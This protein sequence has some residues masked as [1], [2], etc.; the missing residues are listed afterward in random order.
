[1]DEIIE[2]RLIPVIPGQNR[3]TNKLNKT[4]QKKTK[5]NDERDRT[6]SVETVSHNYQV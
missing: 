1:M 4:K 6:V 3:E 2:L 5:Q